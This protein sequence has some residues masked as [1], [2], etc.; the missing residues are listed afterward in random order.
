VGVG[1]FRNLKELAVSIKES[2]MKGQF[3]GQLFDFSKQWLVIY[4]NWIF[5]S[6]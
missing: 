6:F 4:Q 3:Y 2:T 1:Y 5:Y